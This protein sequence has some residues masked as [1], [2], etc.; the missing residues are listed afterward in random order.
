MKRY[1]AIVSGRVQGVGFRFQAQMNA[2]THDLTGW[3]RN[4]SNGDVELE[5]Q[6]DPKNIETFFESLHT[7]RFPAKIK[8][9]E[10]NE[11]EPLPHEKKFVIYH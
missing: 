5:I 4:K 9:I 11:K 3:V 10:Q 7:L 6:G 2:Q 8:H 1:H